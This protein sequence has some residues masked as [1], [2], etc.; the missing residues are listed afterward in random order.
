M[1]ESDGTLTVTVQRSGGAASGVTVQFATG[2]GTATAGQ[3][4]TA[5]TGTLTFGAGETTKTFTVPILADQID[6]PNE[7]FTVTLS[8]VTG[9]AALGTRPPRQ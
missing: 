8:N 1:S 6:E 9:G 4:Y 5:T 3:D 7:T 2:N